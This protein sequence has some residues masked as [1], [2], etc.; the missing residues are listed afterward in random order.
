V[1]NEVVNLACAGVGALGG[2]A[3][4]ALFRPLL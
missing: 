4:Y 1:D 2:G 3:I